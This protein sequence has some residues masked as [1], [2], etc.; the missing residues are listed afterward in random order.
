MTRIIKS[1]TG[2]SDLHSF[3]RVTLN[4]YPTIPGPLEAFA[5][6]LRNLEAGDD[7]SH[8]LGIFEGDSLLGG[9]RCLDFECN[10]VSQMIPAAG[11]GSV[12]V[13]PLARKRG[14]AKDLISYFLDQAEAKEQYLAMLYPFRPDFYHKMGF[15]YGT[16]M[17]Q[18][19]VRP[20]SFPYTVREHRLCYL[21]EEDAPLLARFCDSYAKAHHG[22]CRRSKW[23]LDRLIKTHAER[24]TLV[25]LKEGGELKAYMAFSYRKAHDNN[26][27]KNDLVVNE[28]LWTDPASL[29][30]CT[31]FLHAWA[32]QINRVI[33]NTQYDS[34]HFMLDDVRNESDNVIP[35][36][37]HETHTSG[38]GLMY[39]IICLSKF[40]TFT[41]ARNFNGLTLALQV[42][43]TDTFR[44][45]NAGT[46]HVRFHEGFAELADKPIAR[47]IPLEV[48]IA[49][50]SA[51]LMG[52]TDLLALYRFGRV[53][54]EAAHLELLNRL[55]W[56]PE[57]PVCITGF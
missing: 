49:D 24:G 53:K 11:V 46:Y 32:D 18:F 22:F 36:V 25:G 52:S 39:R 44:A 40:L 16:K 20:A 28:W 42:K 38:V 33:I 55:F 47:A 5:E 54:M 43:L 21:S 30:A 1:L 17:N 13:D 9:M 8:H 23:E 6:R 35:H 37:Y 15:G 34:F 4:A 48:D 51:L 31:S 41:Q 14:V 19:A 2:D 12:A 10:Y 45:K 3:A 29:A 56:L 50:L 7:S 27:V 26:F 57:R